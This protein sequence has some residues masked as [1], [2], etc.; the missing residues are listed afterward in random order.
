M[1]K[2]AANLSFLYQEL[3]FLERVGA[4]ARDGFKAVE[5]LFPFDTVPK[6]LRAALAGHEVRIVLHNAPVGGADAASFAS[7]WQRGE[8]GTA[9]I[10]GKAAEFRA[11]LLYALA[12]ARAV[13][14]PRVHVLSG[15][16]PAD[17]PPERLT[18]TLRANLRWAVKQAAQ[19]DVTLMIEPLNTRDVPGYFLTSQ[20]QA[21]AIVRDIDSQHL[22][23]QMDLYHCQ[24]TEGDLAAKLRQYLPTG[25]VGHIQIAGVPG[26]HEP[27]VGEVNYPYLFGVLDEL[28]YAG[29]VGCEYKPVGDT[30]AGLGWLSCYATAPNPAQT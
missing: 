17:M 13:G 26:R 4:A 24:I 16:A 22:Q 14:C 28:G 3:P 7:A 2:F 29:W 12:Y 20:A 25:R 19:S 11:G 18:D 6:D 9:C 10:P 27:D 30:S 21:H 15:I 5:C 1:P 23:V 8:R